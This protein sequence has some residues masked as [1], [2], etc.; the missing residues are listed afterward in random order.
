MTADLP[1]TRPVPGTSGLPHP[2]GSPHSQT[3]GTGG[4]GTGGTGVSGYGI[5]YHTGYN[6]LKRVRTAPNGGKTGIGTLNLYMLI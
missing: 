4:Y 5:G 1:Q 3:N 6:S 2:P